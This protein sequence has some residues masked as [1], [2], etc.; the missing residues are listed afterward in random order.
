[1]K[2]IPDFLLEIMRQW[3]SLATGGVI[4]GAIGIWQGTGH[5]VAPWVYYMI[6]GSALLVAFFKVWNE[7]V[8]RA[9][10]AEALVKEARGRPDIALGCSPADGVNLLNYYT[11]EEEIGTKGSFIFRVKNGGVSQAV[12]ISVEDIVLPISEE[13]RL[14]LA[15]T[16]R[17]FS[18]QVGVA[19]VRGVA[20]SG[21]DSAIQICNE[22]LPRTGTRNPLYDRQCR[23][24]A[25]QRSRLLFVE[26]GETEWFRAAETKRD[27]EVLE[28]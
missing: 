23:I 5:P 27:A 28:S 18:A 4:V 7:Q 17:V 10:T 24:N 11:Q 12:N 2:R 20:E 3:G 26:H 6:G 1:M 14:R 19:S 9:E 15:E 13:T 25:A 22:R 16:D 21:M 8:V